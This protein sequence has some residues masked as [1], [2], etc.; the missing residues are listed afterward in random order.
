MC[1]GFCEFKIHQLSHTSLRNKHFQKQFFVSSGMWLAKVVIAGSAVAAGVSADGTGHHGGHHP[2]HSPPVFG[3]FPAVHHGHYGHH[4]H[5]GHQKPF[6]SVAPL[7]AHESHQEPAKPE[8]AYKEP[9][10]APYQAPAPAYTYHHP[11]HAPPTFGYVATTKAPEPAY[12]EPEPA[13][14]E[15]EPA[16]K[17]PEPYHPPAPVYASH[18]PVHEPPTIGY[19][20]P[21]K[22]PEPAYKEPEPAYK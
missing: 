22:E 21:A 5:P 16:Y 11:V 4:G 3:H 2:V 13:Y 20:E 14:K 12:K 6:V 7:P 1:V 9:E 15:P 18:H 8:P 10:P 19:V 17:E